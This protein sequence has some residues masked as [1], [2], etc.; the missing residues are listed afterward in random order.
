MVI[1]MGILGAIHFLFV[2]SG[3]SLFFLELLGAVC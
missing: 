1:T 3:G 2:S